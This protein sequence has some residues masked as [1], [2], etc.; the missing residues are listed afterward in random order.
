METN[1][2]H[3]EYM[4]KFVLVG[5]SGV[6]KTSLISR[7]ICNEFNAESKSTL[8]VDFGSTFAQMKDNRRIKLQ[9]WDISG[10]E[11]YQGIAPTYYRG[12]QCAFLLFD[13]TSLSSFVNL[14]VHWL[15]EI[16][17]YASQRIKL[18]LIA[19][20]ADL[21]KEGQQQREI[22]IQAAEKYASDHDMLFFETSA[23]EDNTHIAD[24]FQS[25]AADIYDTLVSP[26]T[27]DG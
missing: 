21:V 11:R 18:V 8:G 17:R 19:N 26:S 27:D 13:P 25:V 5:D 2:Q 22:S 23:L 7:F 24:V 12:A 1:E 20:K 10:K 15:E 4:L 6:G 16:R 14:Q 9:V 3:D